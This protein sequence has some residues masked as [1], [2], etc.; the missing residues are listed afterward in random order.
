MGHSESLQGI[1]D[2]FQY[3]APTIYRKQE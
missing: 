2:E 1:S 3:I